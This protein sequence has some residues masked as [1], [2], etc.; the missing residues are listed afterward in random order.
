M[1]RYKHM[2]RL[3]DHEV[4][5]VVCGLEWLGHEAVNDEGD[6]L[7]DAIKAKFRDKYDRG[8]QIAFDKGRSAGVS[9]DL[10]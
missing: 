2:M 4:Y 6:R 10:S 7:A 5:L 8:R 1:K 3:T 9:P